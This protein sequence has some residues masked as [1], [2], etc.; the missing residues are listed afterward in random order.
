MHW[1]VLIA[2]D[3]NTV[4]ETLAEVLRE[5]GY[6]VVTAADGLQAVHCLENMGIDIALVDIHM[7]GMDG[8]QV[9]ARARE[10]APETLVV[11][12]TAFGTIDSAVKAVKLGASDYVSKPIVFDDI[13]IKI[14]RLLNMHR[15]AEEN[16]FLLTELETR[17][18]FE[19]IVG[20]SAALHRILDLVEKLAETRTSALISGESGTGKELIARAI[21]YSGI[22]KEGRFV[23]I[24]S[25][26]LSENLVES[27]LFGHR[28][29]SFT[30]A[31]RDKT[32]LFEVADRGTVFLD[33]ICSMSASVQAK[34]LRVIE[35][36]Q[37]LPVGAT[38]PIEVNAR[39]LCATNRDLAKEVEEGRFR[40]DLYY[41]LNVVEVHVP[42]LRERKEDIPELANHFV[43]VFNREL[44]KR[45]PGVTDAAMRA[46]MAYAWPGNVRELK[47]V[48]ERAIIFAGAEAIDIENLTFASGQ[49]PEPALTGSDLKV[50]MR[51]YEKQ[52]IQ[53]VLRN[54]GFDKKAAAETLHV[55]LSSL[56]RK[57]AE[58][59]ICENGGE[60]LSQEA[61]A[62]ESTNE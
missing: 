15:L 7:P 29:G 46:M 43:G 28:R 48:I 6:D 27:E 53:Q 24:N 55:G 59:G 34:L 26:A 17:Y 51:A 25:A 58:L 40:E 37:V 10:V 20:G 9:L 42:P 31:T 4:R 54:H 14:E 60:A 49:A 62:T 18:R 36:K 16:R 8:I 3:E 30:G 47:N 23:A 57:L 11:I 45:C 61:A 12:V 22:A 21:H 35:D 41:R 39:F 2:D 50:A 13:I 38:E 44:N 33:E 1:T 5:S 32:G 52:Y 56:Y 19:G